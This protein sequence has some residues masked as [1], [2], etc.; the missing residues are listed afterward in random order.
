MT[1]FSVSSAHYSFMLLPLDF[2]FSSISSAFIGYIKVLVVFSLKTF[3]N[4]NCYLT[5][6]PTDVLF[7]MPAICVVNALEVTIFSS[8][9]TGST[10]SHF[11]MN[12]IEYGKRKLILTD[13]GEF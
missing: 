7:N 12:G 10:S 4:Y 13:K 11:H 2:T 3:Q 5:P 1:V 8:S 6:F 9:G